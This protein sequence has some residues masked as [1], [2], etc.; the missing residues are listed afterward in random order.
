MK[1]SDSPSAAELLK[2]EIR[3]RIK[4]KVSIVGIGNI[5]RAD[6]GLGPK[7]IEIL[8][9]RGVSASS[10]F[11]CGTAPE[12]YALPI[13][14]TSCQT[15]ILVDAIDLG[16]PPGAIRVMDLPD[17]ANVSF[18]THNPSPHL[19]VDLL[20]TGKDDLNVFIIAVQPK[21]TALGSPLSAEVL[22]SL[23]T[24]SEAVSQ[25]LYGLA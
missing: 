12:N 4:G 3:V 5:L 9:N 7:F 15:V 2:R 25:V 11:D 23:D 10:L 8:K 19:F 1:S 24:L 22:S 14:S 16:E 13:L 6:D 17:V 20:R 21:T 18:S